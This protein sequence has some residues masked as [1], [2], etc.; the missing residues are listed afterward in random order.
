MGAS[1]LDCTVMCR[2]CT[3]TAYLHRAGHKGVVQAMLF[4]TSSNRLFAAAG[5]SIMF[6]KTGQN[7]AEDCS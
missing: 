1:H 7:A 5:S 3:H 6:W 2:V 4:S